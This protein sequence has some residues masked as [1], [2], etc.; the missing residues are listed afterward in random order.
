MDYG[1][2]KRIRKE[3]VDGIRPEW[4]KVKGSPWDMAANEIPDA[5]GARKYWRARNASRGVMRNLAN[6]NEDL[7]AELAGIPGYT[8]YMQDSY[9]LNE[10]QAHVMEC[11]SR[12][13]LAACAELD[14]ATRDHEEME[15]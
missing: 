6:E 10:E 5:P 1:E 3:I 7:N 8:S 14:A 9:P 13:F 15:R 2:A 4:E 12:N 11:A